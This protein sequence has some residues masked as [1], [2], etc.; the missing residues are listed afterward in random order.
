MVDTTVNALEY[1]RYVLA[2][3]HPYVKVLAILNI[4]VI[5]LVTHHHTTINTH[6]QL[7]LQVHIVDMS[8]IVCNSIGHYETNSTNF[9]SYMYSLKK[10]WATEQSNARKDTCMSAYLE[11]L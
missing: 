11:F 3:K 2:S 6:V 10:K 1:C 7:T 8:D 9:K 5:I 4:A